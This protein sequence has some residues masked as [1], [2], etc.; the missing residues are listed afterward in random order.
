LDEDLRPEHFRK[1]PPPAARFT[2]SDIVIIGTITAVEPLGPPQQSK[3]KSPTAVRFLVEPI[4]IP[5]SIENA[6]KGSP[7]SSNIDVY[8]YIYSSQ[9]T[10]QFG[11]PLPFDAL[12]GQRRLL[13]LRSEGGRIRLLHD[14][15]DYSLRVFSGKHDTVDP[16]LA[17]TPG[18]AI[19]WVLL[20]RGDAANAEGL[21]NWMIEYAW[22]AHQFGGTPLMMDLL[23]RLAADPDRQIRYRASELIASFEYG[24]R[25][26]EEPFPVAR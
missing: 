7:P 9:N 1:F 10:R 3:A 24:L 11:H 13:F 17:S 22:Y 23:R 12:P 21:A 5:V 2:Q 19:S 4:R 18:A 20:T 25:R 8:G 15:F 14:V 26:G 6:F 16:A